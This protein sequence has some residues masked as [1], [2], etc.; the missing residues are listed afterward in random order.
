MEEVQRELG[1][2]ERCE[3]LA[4]DEDRHIEMIERV[5]ANLME[6]EGLR[7]PAPHPV[8]EH[9]S[10]TVIINTASTS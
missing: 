5:L 3:Q 8:H 9:A 7:Q 6:K 1:L 2:A 4:L 10:S